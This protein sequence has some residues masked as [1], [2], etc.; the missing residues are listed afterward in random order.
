MTEPTLTPAQLEDVAVVAGRERARLAKQQQ[1]ARKVEEQ[2]KAAAAPNADGYVVPPMPAG[3]MKLRRWLRA[4]HDAYSARRIG[5][6]ELTEMRR[7]VATQSDTYKA[8]AVVRQSHAAMQ[9]A[10]AQTRM[11]DVLA[12]IEHGG[13]VVAFMARLQETVSNGA[14]RR[15]LPRVRA[16]LPAVTERV[17]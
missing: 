13:A 3:L 2:A 10:E 11:A 12:S 14:P 1:R 6:L 7:S 4:G 5:L 16:A 8:G 17:S 15:P 9:A